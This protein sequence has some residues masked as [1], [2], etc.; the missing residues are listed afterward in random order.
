MEAIRFNTT[1]SI[2][3]DIA[4]GGATTIQQ[5]RTKIRRLQDGRKSDTTPT[6]PV[7]EDGTGP[8]KYHSYKD[9]QSLTPE[10]KKALLVARGTL[11]T[12]RRTP[13]TPA[14]P[15]IPATSTPTELP[16]PGSLDDAGSRF[17]LTR[18]S[19]LTWT[20]YQ[21]QS[22]RGALI[23]P[24]ERPQPRSNRGALLEPQERPQPRFRWDALPEPQVRPQP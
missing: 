21:T 18:H 2:R 12:A 5:L 24:Q 15:A 17:P 16:E 3:D 6:T 4:D 10:Q 13:R 1:A 11:R 8:G 20:E 19:E 14:P 7:K 23:E 22:N 9:W